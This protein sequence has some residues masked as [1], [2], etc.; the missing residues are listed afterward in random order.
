MKLSQLKHLKAAAEYG[1]MSKAAEECYISQS[2]FSNSIGSLEVELNAILLERSNKG[3]HL[4]KVGESVLEKTRD[5]LN[6]IDDIHMLTKLNSEHKASISTIPCMNDFI[7]PHALTKL[8]VKNESLN[9]TIHTQES[10]RIVNDVLNGSSCLGIIIQ[11]PELH[12]KH[13]AYEKLPPI[14]ILFAQGN[15]LH[16]SNRPASRS[17][18]FSLSLTLPIAKNS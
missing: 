2:T 12:L 15:Y 13:L 11:S 16:F 17:K 9:L 18:P 6:A 5:I 14:A 4:T 8:S 10:N 7:L 3:V 1:S